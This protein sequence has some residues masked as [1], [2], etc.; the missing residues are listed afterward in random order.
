MT[1]PLSKI[2]QDISTK[3]GPTKIGFV[4]G[5]FCRG[6]KGSRL[7][8]LN[9]GA[10]NKITKQPREK[11]TTSLR[12]FFGRGYGRNL[13]NQQQEIHVFNQETVL[14]LPKGNFQK[15]EKLTGTL[16]KNLKKENEHQM[17]VKKAV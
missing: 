9:T 14:V 5:L 17:M 15:Q 8:V 6:I 1:H 4:I 12:N 2:L 11:V 10:Y 16:I 3:I 13:T 7:N